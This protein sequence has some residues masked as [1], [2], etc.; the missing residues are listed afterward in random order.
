[1]VEPDS[2]GAAEVGTSKTFAPA[3]SSQAR[4]RPVP[5]DCC[6]TLRLR[7]GAGVKIAALPSVLTPRDGPARDCSDS[8][9]W[10]QLLG[11]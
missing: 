5:E 3:T 10:P 11:R 4:A 2:W 7:A 9:V 6:P 8:K 1:M